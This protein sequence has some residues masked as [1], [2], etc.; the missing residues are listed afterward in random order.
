MTDRKAKRIDPL[1]R[2]QRSRQM[3]LVRAKDT[4]PEMRVRRAAHGMGF[5]YRLHEKNII[6][7]P[8][9]VF[10]SKHKVIFVHGCFWHRH[11]GCSRCRLPK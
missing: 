7:C 2:K 4:K 11:K 3:A 5:R 10:P 1:S 6:G 8:D 9:M